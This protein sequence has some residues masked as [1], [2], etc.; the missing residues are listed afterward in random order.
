MIISNLDIEAVNLMHLRDMVIGDIL[1]DTKAIIQS[2]AMVRYLDNVDNKKGAL[3]E[4]L[5][6]E[7]LELFTLG[8]GNYTE[9]DL[10]KYLLLFSEQLSTSS[11]VSK[12]NR[13]LF[14]IQTLKLI[15]EAEN[16]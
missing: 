10:D 13:R 8:I 11:T 4:N 6:R 14:E 5:S 9:E 12:D 1:M 3:N 15:E 7:L 16:N 2:N